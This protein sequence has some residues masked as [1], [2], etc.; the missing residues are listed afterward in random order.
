MM[1]NQICSVIRIDSPLAG[2]DQNMCRVTSHKR[3]RKNMSES[4]DLLFQR[5]D[6]AVHDAVSS[7]P[8]YGVKFALPSG[9]SFDF[10]FESKSVTGGNPVVENFKS[11]VTSANRAQIKNWSGWLV[12]QYR[13]VSSPCSTDCFAV[14]PMTTGL[15]CEVDR[16][17]A[18]A[19][20]SAVMSKQVMQYYVGTDVTDA[21]IRKE[22]I[23]KLTRPP[24]PT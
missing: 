7:L 24:M 12:E 11:H 10:K 6:P 22:L 17:A 15:Q 5:L 4:Q 3:T 21:D 20:L 23:G 9:S 2:L 19:L 18:G 13:T 16:E 14:M 1:I 8:D